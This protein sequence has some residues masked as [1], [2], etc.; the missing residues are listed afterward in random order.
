MAISNDSVINCQ[1]FP[2]QR[3]DCKSFEELCKQWPWRKIKCVVADKGYDT[4]NVRNIIKEHHA[5][6]VI[7]P[8]GV[9]LPEGSDLTTEDFYDTH[10]YRKRHIIERLFGRLKE[11]KRI[12]MR[13]DK[14]DSM[15]LS[16][17]A[18][19]LAKLF[20]L[21]CYQCHIKLNQNNIEIAVGTMDPRLRGD[22]N[23]L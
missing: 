9:Y 12:A 21:F 17:I 4:R 1:L 19:A 11:N 23:M 15:F 3:Q 14:L 10:T 18:L 6:P 2:A 16:F 20:K 8:K 22:D 13:F 7:P 5:E